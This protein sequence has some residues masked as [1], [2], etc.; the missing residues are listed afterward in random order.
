MVNAVTVNGGSAITLAE[1]QTTTVKL[2]A[3]VTDNNACGDIASVSSY[4]Y[5]S[6]ITYANCNGDED[7]NNNNCYANVSCS[8]VG[9]GNT[10][11]GST[12]ASADYECDVSVQYHADS[13]VADTQYPAQDWLDTLYAADEALNDNTEVAAGVEMNTTT[14]LDVTASIN[15]G[16]LNVGQSNDPLDKITVVTATGNVGLDEE[17]KGT[18][19]SGDPT[20]TITVGYQKYALAGSTAYASGTSLTTEDVLQSSFDCDKTTDHTSP[21]TKN[22]WWGLEIPTGTTFG[23]YSGSNTVTAAMD[24]SANW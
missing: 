23:T 15:Y 5:R 24:D 19:M 2:T 21:A 3:T 11:D 17:L 20:G 18:D 9:S 7:D 22:T 14:A 10:C 8:V 1:G 13:T 12:D 16:N 4:L 6:A